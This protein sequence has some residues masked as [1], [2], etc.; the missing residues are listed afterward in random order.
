MIQKKGGMMLFFK[1]Y[2]SIVIFKVR[3]KNMCNK[4]ALNMNKQR[5]QCP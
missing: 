5:K 2:K 1:N 3:Y 4:H